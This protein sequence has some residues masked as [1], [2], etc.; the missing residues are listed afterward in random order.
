VQRK[1]RKVTIIPAAAWI[2]D[3]TIQLFHSARHESATVLRGK[4]TNIEDGW[5]PIDYSRATQV[6]CFDFGT[7]V[8]EN[9]RFAEV[10]VRWISR[11]PHYNRFPDIGAEEHAS[12]KK[13]VADVTE[14][15]DWV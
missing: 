15:F 4:R 2:C 10:I 8:A 12:L 3:G 14:L 9:F 11:E 6:R 5:P 13:R 1:Y 7:C